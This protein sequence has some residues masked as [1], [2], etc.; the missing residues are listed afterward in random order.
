MPGQ[1][2]KTQF[3]SQPID[4]CIDRYLSGPE[5]VEAAARAIEENPDNRRPAPNLAY[6]TK[7]K[8]TSQRYLVLE[9]GKLWAIRKRLKINFLGGSAALRG[10]VQ[11]VVMDWE[12]HTCVSFEFGN[13]ASPDIRISFEPD[14]G[15]W[16]WVGTDALV[17]PQDEATMN[18]AICDGASPESI[19]H[20]ILHEFGHVLGAR[21]EHQSPAADIPWNKEAAYEYYTGPPNCWSRDDVDRN[22]FQKYSADFT[23]F[24]EFDPDSIM[25]Y[26]IPPELTD[27]VFEVA[28]NTELSETDQEFMAWVYR[29]IAMDPID[30][31]KVGPPF[32]GMYFDTLREQ[33]QSPLDI[34]K[35][36]SLENHTLR[37]SR[38]QDGPNYTKRR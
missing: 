24:T 2:R 20:V 13:H 37:A 14:K 3:L 27:G 34:I 4:V 18:L 31:P 26:A 28:W 17:I 7:A 29:C 23:Q 6:L 19:N 10:Q 30:H 15:H 22:V 33:I 11:R 8:K 1:S 9:T 32:F 21:H 5:S 16:S 35:I 25:V 12:P 38:I 36:D